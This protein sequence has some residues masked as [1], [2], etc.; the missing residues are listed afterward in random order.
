M[1]I[2][3][4]G[5]SG[6][7]KDT[8]LGLARQALA[9]DPRFRFV[10]RVITRPADAG[11]EDHEA[12]PEA[13]FVQRSFALQWQA[14]GL[15]YGI[16][17]DVIDDLSRDIVVVANVSRG[18]IKEA[19]ERFPARVI[20]VTAPPEILAQRLAARGRET[21]DDVANRLARN[22]PIP[23]HVAVDVIVNDSTPAAAADR[24]A[25]ILIRA[26]LSVQQA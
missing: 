24:F 14:H 9:G 17:L 15:F 7:G 3:V 19:A 20:E 4:V 1:L 6:A 23:D 12:V 5:P 13:V 11:G 25:N 8:V 22:V 21:A 26:A 2:L 18:V 16:P 10:R